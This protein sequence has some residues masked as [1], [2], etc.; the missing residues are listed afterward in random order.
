[1]DNSIEWRTSDPVTGT[2]GIFGYS[3]EGST[4]YT[5]EIEPMGQKIHPHDPVDPPERT[6]QNRLNSAD[7]PEWMCETSEYF[8]G[9]FLAIPT[10][11]LIKNLQEGWI[12]NPKPWFGG[13]DDSDNM[14][15]ALAS[16]N[17]AVRR[18]VPRG[19]RAIDFEGI[20]DDFKDASYPGDD[21]FGDP[22]QRLSRTVVTALRKNIEDNVSADC[23]A[24]IEKLINQVAKDLN[25]TALST[26]ILELFDKVFTNRAADYSGIWG[27]TDYGVSA[28]A[29]N[30]PTIGSLS[31]ALP[32]HMYMYDETFTTPSGIS[33]M[34]PM[35]T[36]AFN[37][38]SKGERATRQYR[39]LVKFVTGSQGA[40]TTIHELI[41]NS[42]GGA[43]DE[44]LA[45]AITTLTGETLNLDAFKD[46]SPLERVYIMSEIWD[47][48][49]NAG[50]GRK[51]SFDENKLKK[52]FR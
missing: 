35:S 3:S 40:F 13:S 36:T 50:C 34:A 49:L 11:C 16:T 17:K 44:A 4:F 47:N 22:A 1:M 12:G 5:E 38:L 33:Y 20:Y 26:N 25:Q 14:S 32:V 6:L 27:Y 24:F 46:L 9:S 2:T 31:L 29:Y 19:E 18:P 52:Y 41:H 48:R 51:M 21:Y 7:E 43:R 10:S 45:I 39:S 37:Q 23:K 30:D 28:R 15:F 8:Q 42:V